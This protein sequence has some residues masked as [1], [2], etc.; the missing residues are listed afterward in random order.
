MSTVYSVA[1]LGDGHSRG[2][3]ITNIDEEVLD[4][5][6]EFA[7]ANGLNFKKAN[8]PNGIEYVI[9]GPAWRNFQFSQS[10]KHKRIFDDFREIAL[11]LGFSMT[12]KREIKTCV[13]KGETKYCPAFRGLLTGSGARLA[14]IPVRIPR[15]KFLFPDRKT[16]RDLLS[17]KLVPVVEPEQEGA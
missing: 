9:T 1:W 15:K 6:R 8:A 7:T 14:Q 12:K 11:S 16:R 13:Y 4:A 2:T 5:F 17:F 10:E 3:R